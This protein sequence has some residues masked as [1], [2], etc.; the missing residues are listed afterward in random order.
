MAGQKKNEGDIH[1]RQIRA[2]LLNKY[3]PEHP[4]AKIDVRRY[5]SVSVRVRIIDPDFAGY[6]QTARDTL[7][8]AF[9]DTLPEDVLAEISLLV[10]LTP[11]EARTSLMNR[12]FEDPMPT[13]L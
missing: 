11:Q 8:W 6:T 13:L 10:L 3:A 1:V 2:K 4:K 7:V 12:E 9:L 5:N